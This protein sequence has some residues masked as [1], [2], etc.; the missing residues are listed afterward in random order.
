MQWYT[1]GAW[2]RGCSPPTHAQCDTGRG[3]RRT[4]A[5]RSTLTSATPAAD[6]GNQV[7][8]VRE[9]APCTVRGVWGSEPPGPHSTVALAPQDVLPTQRAVAEV[10]D[11]LLAKGDSLETVGE[12]FGTRVAC[13]KGTGCILGIH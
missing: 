4:P 5:P 6:F 2:L 1:R 11:L 3:V 13:F 7:S 12:C 8:C 9:H 10:K